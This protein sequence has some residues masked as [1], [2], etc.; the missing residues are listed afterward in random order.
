MPMT[1]TPR[2]SR[3]CSSV[4]TGYRG[5]ARLF[6]AR[7]VRLPAKSPDRFQFRDLIE[8]CADLAS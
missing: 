5:S 8:Q 4:P 1:P 3:R 2:L 7:K 6:T